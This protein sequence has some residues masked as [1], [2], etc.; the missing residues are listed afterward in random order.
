MKLCELLDDVAVFQDVRIVQYIYD[1]HAE[2]LKTT[3]D[4]RTDNFS[5]DSKIPYEI[6]NSVV[7]CVSTEIYQD[8]CYLLIEVR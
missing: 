8:T 3:Y 5:T 1:E 2:Q 7:R 6:M 4:E